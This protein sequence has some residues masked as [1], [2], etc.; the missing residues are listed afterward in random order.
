LEEAAALADAG[1]LPEA[2]LFAGEVVP[3]ATGAP[4]AAGAVDGGLGDVWL[5]LAVALAKQATSA[6]TAVGSSKR[7]EV[8]ASM[9]GLIRSAAKQQLLLS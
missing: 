7:Y 4:L 9:K 6:K 1:V 5:R 2:V 8:S 3:L